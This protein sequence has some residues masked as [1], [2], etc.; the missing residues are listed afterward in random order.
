L[1]FFVKEDKTKNKQITQKMFNEAIAKLN[2]LLPKQCLD[3]R[4]R[5]LD[6]KD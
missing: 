5:V 4:F 2:L 6:F 3:T 1:E